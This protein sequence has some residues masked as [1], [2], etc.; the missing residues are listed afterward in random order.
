M[1]LAEVTTTIEPIVLVFGRVCSG[2][3]TFCKQYIKQGYHHVTTSDIV[4]KVSGMKTRGELQGTGDMD[5]QIADKM[6]DTIKSNPKII[7]DGIRQKSIVERIIREFGSKQ[8]DLIWLD[9]PSDVRKERFKDRGRDG[10][11]DGFDKAEAG[12]SALG[13]DDL[14]SHYRGVTKVVDNY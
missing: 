5:Q 14:E 9:A 11:N 4:R 8:I 12:D 1:I 13:L 10:D 7:I 2:K 6:I 3:E